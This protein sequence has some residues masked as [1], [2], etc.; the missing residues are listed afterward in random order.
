MPRAKFATQNA[1][2]I[3]NKAFEASGI[4]ISETRS[5]AGDKS[6]RETGTVD[7]IVID[8]KGEERLLPFVLKRWMLRFAL[9]DQEVLQQCCGC[10]GNSLMSS[11][12]SKRD[13]CSVNWQFDWLEGVIGSA[14]PLR[15]SSLVSNSLEREKI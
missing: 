7:I 9:F 15:H 2:I 6:D 3:A 10:D 14:S 12:L 1:T 5:L 13:G 4:L 8:D 11:V